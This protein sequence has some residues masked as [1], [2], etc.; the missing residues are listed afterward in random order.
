MADAYERL[1]SL[2]IVDALL[3][4]G[5]DASAFKVRKQGTEFSGKCPIYVGKTNN[6]VSL[7]KT[8]SEV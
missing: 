1:L 8:P 7:P 4:S 3:A 2:P 6:R 5:W